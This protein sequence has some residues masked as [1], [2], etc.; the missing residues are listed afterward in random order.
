MPRRHDFDKFDLSKIGTGEGAQAYGHGL[1]FAENPATAQT[2]RAD[3]GYVGRVMSGQP[4]GVEWDAQRI[5]QDALDTHRE[6]AADHL[7]RVLR[8]N[9][10]LRHQGQAAEN[11]KVQDA[12]ALIQAG[13]VRPRGRMYEVAINADPDS[14]LDWDA[15]I[16]QQPEGIRYV[17]GGESGDPRGRDIYTDLMQG[18]RDVAIRAGRNA[19]TT[20]PRS[21][22]AASEWLR[23]MGVPG[24]KYLDQGSRSA[25]EGTRNYVMFDDSIID[26]LKKWGIVPGAV[27]GGKLSDLL[28]QED[29]R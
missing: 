18:Q 27:A 12:I 10:G 13:T 14:L 8:S 17:F 6:N 9:S 5:A 2:Y 20:L 29:Q 23:E 1:Y 16:S 4:G 7:A 22:S 19:D 24:I 3:R 21:Q 28:P 26:I 11:Q 15:P 25:G